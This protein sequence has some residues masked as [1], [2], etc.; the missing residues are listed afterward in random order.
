MNNKRIVIWNCER[1]PEQNSD[2]Y[3]CYSIWERDGEISAQLIEHG[4]DM[5]MKFGGDLIIHRHE[6][7]ERM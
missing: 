3:K 4:V 6:Y 2:C 5:A 1:K 7:I